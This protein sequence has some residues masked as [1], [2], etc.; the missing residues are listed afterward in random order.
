[1]PRLNEV[2]REENES[3]LV[4]QMYGI[5]FG[6]RDPVD[7]P[8]TAT[9]TPGDW[10]TVFAND[11]AVF[12]HAVQGFGVYRGAKLNP[13]LRELGQTRAGW[14]VG[15]QFVYS[16]HC[17]S[18]RGLGATEEQIAGIAVGAGAP[19]WNELERLVLGYA[20]CLVAGQGRVPDAIFEGLRAHLPDEQ[21]LELTYI[22]C[23]YSQHAVMSK[24]L[25]TEFDDVD[26]RIVEVAAPEGFDPRDIVRD[27][28]MP[29]GHRV[30]TT[31]DEG[32]K[33]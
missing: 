26:E 1:M 8:G 2:S 18:M 14:L 29:N 31:S 19:C 12:K 27:I 17:K 11:H 23:L 25:R 16:Q 32:E 22:T 10:W 9:G 33:E 20:D 24:A 6:G 21:I 28:S 5:L 4:E 7:E 3:P 30:N 15:S 13:M